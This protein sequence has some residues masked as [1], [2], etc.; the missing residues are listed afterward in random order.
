M[1]NTQVVIIDDTEINL[2]LMKHLV[3]KLDG[4]EAHCFSDSAQG[5][6]WCL[7]NSPDLIIVD[8][9]MPAPDGLEFIRR[10][11]AATQGGIDIPV[12]MIT[13]NDQ[14]EVRYQALEAGANDFLTKPVD[15]VE[16]HGRLKNM[17]TLRDSQKKLADHAAWLADEVKK[18]T[19]QI[20]ARENEI[21][22][23]LS[24]ATDYRDPETGAHILRM[25]HYAR[26]IAVNLGMEE[27]ARGL[28]FQA[29]P[30]HDIGKV[31]IPDHVLLKPG[32]YEPEE[33][34][35]MKRHARI[36]HEI[37]ARSQVP[38]LRA[39][40]EIALTHHEKFNGGGYPDGRKG[41]EIPLFGRICA[42]ADVFDALT[43]V[44]PYKDAWDIERAVALL[45]EEAGGHFDPV[46]VEAFL[47]NWGE[48]L[49]IKQGIQDDP[50]A[51]NLP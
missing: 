1:A 2:T 32:K 27:A 12:L 19:A 34:E 39:G 14:K 25:A 51:G 42:V 26:H 17:R 4:C 48:V 38:V 40:A 9:V 41:E 35:I 7:A 10:F 3:K 29:A 5:L 20:L 22:L 36:G 28:L 49:E 50:P 37:L 44:R 46:C 45:R 11:R 15:T 21:I 6:Q 18:A 43:S 8:Y 31:G 13:A 23:R 33:F 30:M 24:K 16:F 47:M